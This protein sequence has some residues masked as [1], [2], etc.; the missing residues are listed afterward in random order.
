MNKKNKITRQDKKK[1]VEG[2]TSSVTYPSKLLKPVAAFLQ[3]RLKTLEFRRKSVDEDD[4]F[5]DTSRLTDN[6]SPDADAEE[7]FGHARTSA[8]RDQLDRK[9]IQTKK[10]LTRIKV[11]KYGL[12]EDC[13]KMIDTDR[14]MVY[15]EATLCADCQANREQ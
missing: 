11:G 7:Q 15:P 6:A 5:K 3:N 14:L 13:G 2:K 1:K 9:I 4:P 8:I 12:C 10:A